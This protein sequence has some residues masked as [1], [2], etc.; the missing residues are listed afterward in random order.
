MFTPAIDP[1]VYTLNIANDIMVTLVLNPGRKWMAEPQKEGSSV[2][3]VELKVKGANVLEG[4][5][6]VAMVIPTP[7][8]LE[9][10]QI[11]Y[12]KASRQFAIN[13]TNFRPKKTELIF[14]PPLLRNQDY[15]LNVAS[16]K[17]LVL[18]RTTGHQWRS[19]PGPLKLRRIDTGGGQLRVRRHSDITRERER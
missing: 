3:L 4:A 5:E 18:T 19:D 12:T 17:T 11:V 8:V 1:S 13:G 7:S 2:F 16:T 9:S 6:D 10:E 15:I 14:D